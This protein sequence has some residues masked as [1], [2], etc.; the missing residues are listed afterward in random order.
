MAGMTQRTWRGR[1][2]LGTLAGV[3]ALG[4][5]DPEDG[6]VAQAGLL[7][8]NL[9]RVRAVVRQDR[10]RHRQA[11]REAA[12]RLGRALSRE[13]AERE[14]RVRRALL[15]LT[16]P[17]RGVPALIT[18]QKSFIA[19]IDTEGVVVARDV[20]EAEDD[21]M[22]GAE[23]GERY[24]VVRDALEHGRAGYTLAEFPS[25]TGEPGYA[26]MWVAPVSHEGQRVGALAI[27]ILLS[28]EARRIANQLK[29]EN[30]VSGRQIHVYIYRGET[31]YHRDTP[32]DLT[33]EI[34]EHSAGWIRGLAQHPN[35][36]TGEF[37]AYQ[38][39]WGFALLPLTSLGDDIGV[40]VVRGEP[41]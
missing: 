16:A 40:L 32:D 4:A 2:I 9:P 17:P 26:L 13:P 11:T 15:S 10:N 20:E 1:A 5:C 38:R 21:R 33:A 18:S 34:E 22:R 39:S 28:S 12:G 24:D 8:E 7:S 19:A 35:G 25:S 3:L 14:P 29:L 41:V 6:Q 36:Y 31:L 27:G 23:F 30:G 37:R